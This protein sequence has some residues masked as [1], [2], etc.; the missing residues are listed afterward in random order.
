[1]LTEVLRTRV[2]FFNLRCRVAFGGKQRCSES[3]QHS[4]FS[5]DALMGLG[6][7]LQ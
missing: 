2:G 7:R 1:M 4:Y 3:D 6:Q 5:L